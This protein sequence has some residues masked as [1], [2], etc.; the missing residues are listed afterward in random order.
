MGQK[1]VWHKLSIYFGLSRNRMG[2]KKML[3]HKS[4]IHLRLAANPMVRLTRSSQ[5]STI[6]IKPYTVSDGAPGKKCLSGLHLQRELA[7]SDGDFVRKRPKRLHPHQATLEIR[8]APGK[9]KPNRLHPHRKRGKSDGPNRHQKHKSAKKA[10]QKP[11]TRSLQQPS[12]RRARTAR[13]S[14]RRREEFPAG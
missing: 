14:S 13:T 6:H 5:M 4:S 11:P 1:I 8:W 10:P 12:H 9:N 3:W 2:A 7:V